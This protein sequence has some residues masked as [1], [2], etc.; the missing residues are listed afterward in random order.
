LS[1]IERILGGIEGGSVIDVATQAGHFTQ[2]LME[3][4]KSYTTIIGVDI[5]QGAI[6]SAQNNLGSA[7]V[8][9]RVMD[10]ERLGFENACFDTV[11]IS[12]SLHHFA[13]IPRVLAEMVRVLKPGGHFILIE[14]HRDGQT[15]AALTSV[16]LH[17]W[18]A[19]V[20][21]ALGNLH[22][23]TLARQEFENHVADLRLRDIA[24][25]YDHDVDSDPKEETRLEQLDDLIERTMQRAESAANDAELK[26][27]GEQLRTRLH[28]IGVQR[29]PIIIIVGEK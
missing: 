21:A 6:E 23:R 18:V 12:A 7:N 19:E 1:V 16:Y 17:E 25:H 27:R 10:V 8:R 15:E 28:D 9:F 5:N 13:N 11:T 26:A 29:E 14:M 2:I 20:D 24:F 4:L 3:Y 22:N